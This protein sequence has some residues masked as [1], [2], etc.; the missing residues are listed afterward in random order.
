MCVTLSAIRLLGLLAFY[1]KGGIC[2]MFLNIQNFYKINS[3][4][5][6]NNS[7]DVI[8]MTFTVAQA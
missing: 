7:F 5:G 8:S 2:K 1:L 4:M 6:R 3:R